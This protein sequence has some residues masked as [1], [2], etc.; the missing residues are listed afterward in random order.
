MIDRCCHPTSKVWDRYGGRG[1]TVCD[2]WRESFDAFVADMGVPEP[3]MTLERIDNDKGYSPENC[4]WATMQEQQRNRRDTV[5]LSYKG[6]K[7]C[8][9]EWAK[10]LNVSPQAI[11]YRLKAGYSVEEAITKKFRDYPRDY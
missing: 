8:I 10:E 3:G 5:Y 6:K 7:K 11:S 9:A 4:R 2:R 1:I